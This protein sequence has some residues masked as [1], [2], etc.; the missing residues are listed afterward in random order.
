MFSALGYAVLLI[1][2]NNYVLPFQLMRLS[3]CG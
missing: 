3:V 1:A 2:H